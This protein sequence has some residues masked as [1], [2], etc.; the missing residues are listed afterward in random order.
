ALDT[1]HA[2]RPRDL[3][4]RAQR[5]CVAREIYGRRPDPS[6]RSRDQDELRRHGRLRPDL[7]ILRPPADDRARIRDRFEPHAAQTA[8]ERAL[9][10][11]EHGTASAGEFV[12]EYRQHRA[13]QR[14]YRAAR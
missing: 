1:A 12:P 2:H 7:W 9:L 6:R 5:Y 11:E 10:R 4:N 8:H 3:R 13:W 14:T